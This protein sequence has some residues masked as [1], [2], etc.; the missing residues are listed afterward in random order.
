MMPSMIR[1]GGNGLSGPPIWVDTLA[2]PSQL[3]RLLAKRQRRQSAETDQ[4]PWSV[5]NSRYGHWLAIYRGSYVGASSCKD[6]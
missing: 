4:S 5:T 6:L 3:L 1:G 2:A